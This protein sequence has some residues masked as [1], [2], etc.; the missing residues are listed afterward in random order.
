MAA[1]IPKVISR[2][3]KSFHD[4]IVSALDAGKPVQYLLRDVK[5]ALPLLDSLLGVALRASLRG[6]L[7][8]AISAIEG[9]RSE[10]TH[11][12]GYI[13]DLEAELEAVS[14]QVAGM[15]NLGRSAEAVSQ[16]PAQG[17]GDP[18]TEG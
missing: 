14:A 9:M 15:T 8:R 7:D 2:A 10:L 16:A 12:E 13:R 1:S 17:E 3:A 11:A 6:V 4:V 5:L 18:V